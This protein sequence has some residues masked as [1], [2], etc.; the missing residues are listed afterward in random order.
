MKD[1]FNYC[2]TFVIGMV[3]G[4]MC[5][6]SYFSHDYSMST[7]PI[8]EPEIIVVEET[9]PNMIIIPEN[10]D[11]IPVIKMSNYYCL[12][13]EEQ[14]MLERL[15]MAEARGEDSKGKAL[16]M[17][18]AINRALN[19]GKSIEEVIYKPGAFYTAGMYLIPDDDCHEALAMI[20]EG[21]DESQGALYFSAHGYSKYGEPL[22]QY[23][24]H[25]FSK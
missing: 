15:A 3:I 2:A 1:T 5:V 25:Y 4:G 8:N 17:R 10:T 18:V 19:S 12:S 22:F 21:W 6:G 24:G 20:N 14:N 11:E 13:F 16:V 23:G 7:K 9:E